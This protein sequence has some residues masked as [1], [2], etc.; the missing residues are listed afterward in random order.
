MIC[1]ARC[2]NITLE[3]ARCASRTRSRNVWAG[4]QK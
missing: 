2:C 1:E 4:V 3:H